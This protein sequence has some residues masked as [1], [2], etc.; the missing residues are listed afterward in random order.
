IIVDDAIVVSEDADTHRRR[1]E[2]PEQAALGGARRMYWPVVASSLTTVAAFVPLMLV[3]GIIGNVMFDIP[4]V[5]IMVI[6]AALMES[7][8]ILPAHLKSALQGEAGHHA[9]R[10][11]ERL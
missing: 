4:F 11:R 7:F 10:L 2:G 9:S 3:G 8:L 5:M 1:G 6:L